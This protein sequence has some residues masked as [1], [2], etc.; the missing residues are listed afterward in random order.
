MEPWLHERADNEQ[1][2]LFIAV[3]WL[4]DLE[5]VSYNNGAAISAQDLLPATPAA[6]RADQM[7]V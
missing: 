7:S 3:L 6:W 4:I 1:S 2:R 5:M